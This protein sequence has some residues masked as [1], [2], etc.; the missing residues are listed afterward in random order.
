MLAIMAL[1]GHKDLKTTMAL[2]MKQRTEHM[3]HSHRRFSAVGWRLH[4][5]WKPQVAEKRVIRLEAG[6]ARRFKIGFQRSS[7][8]TRVGSAGNARL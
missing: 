5:H 3:S 7:L 1:M 2:H 4:D 6:V 8:P